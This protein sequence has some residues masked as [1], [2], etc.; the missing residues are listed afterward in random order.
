MDDKA[1][2]QLA[3]EYLFLQKAVE[4][5]DARA[6]TIKAW[7]VTFSASGL[8]LAYQQDKPALLLVAA[9][10]AAAFWIVEAVWKYY[11][12]GIYPRIFAIEAWFRGHAPDE[13]SAPFQISTSWFNVEPH[14]AKR[15]AEQGD[16]RGPGWKVFLYVGV[17]MPHV[18]VV[19]AGLSLFGLHLLSR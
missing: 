4:D 10:S 9:G 5:F 8:G 19:A 13:P 12:Y 14:R 2:D 15:R 18:F 17:M 1:A 16:D 7:S 6:L 3:Q 11:Q